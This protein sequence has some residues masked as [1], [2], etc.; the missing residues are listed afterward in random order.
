MPPTVRWHC[1][2]SNCRN[3]DQY[4]F[5]L[6]QSETIKLIDPK[7]LEQLYGFTRTQVVPGP[8]AFNFKLDM[9]VKS[10]GLGLYCRAFGAFFQHSVNYFDSPMKIQYRLIKLDTLNLKRLQ[11]LTHFG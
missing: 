6:K 5:R 7:V 10:A 2:S 8:T 4:G 3:L 11:T 9:S 1:F